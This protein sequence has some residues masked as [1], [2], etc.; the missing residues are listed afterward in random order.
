M[1]IKS[2]PNLRRGTEEVR[3]LLLSAASQL[4]AAKGFDATTTKEI[5][6]VSGV[7]EPVLFSNFGSKAGL[8]EAAVVAPF[9][10]LVE[11]YEASWREQALTTEARVEVFVR[12]LFDLAQ[13]NKVLLLS[14]MLLRSINGRN[15]DG[16]IL[17]HVADAFQ[18]MQK[19]PELQA[20]AGDYGIDTPVSIAASAGMVVGVAVLDDMLFSTGARRPGRKRLI[21]ELTNMILHGVAHRLPPDKRRRG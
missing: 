17:D 21:A 11:R 10:E 20:P 1:A 19:A 5:C 9:K 16:D 4:F 7:S 2:A 8:F 13:E 3:A 6:T 14:S 18:A 15:P 12:E